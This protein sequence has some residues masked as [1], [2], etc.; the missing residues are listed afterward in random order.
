MVMFMIHFIKIN[1]KTI[2]VFIIGFS[3]GITLTILLRPD[4][5]SQLKNGEEKVVSIDNYTITADTLYE[6]LKNMGSVYIIINEIDAKILDNLYETTDEM[7]EEVTS[8]ANYYL[9][10]ASNY[11]GYSVTAF[12]SSN[13]FTSF[14]DFK[15]NLIL[16]YKRNLYLTD[17]LKKEITEEEIKNF[18]NDL[19]GAMSGKYILIDDLDTTKKI[20][21]DLK[22]GKTYSEIIN[23]YN[24]KINIKA[25]KNIEFDSNIEDE[26]YEELKNLEVNSYS[27]NYFNL[28][29]KYVVVFKDD[30]IEKASLED[31]NERIKI[32]LAEEKINQ[33]DGTI[34]NEILNDLREKYNLHFFDTSIEKEYLNYLK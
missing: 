12:L 34:A 5:I 20:L 21:A 8:E 28:N 26:I 19:T 6:S 30:E 1:K 13:G 22:S 33:D 9:N 25:L 18:Y 23:A 31:L 27:N 10:T 29:D 4:A 16:E 3:I 24:D 2:L 11:Y 7:I 14:E 32:Y 17:Y 15:N